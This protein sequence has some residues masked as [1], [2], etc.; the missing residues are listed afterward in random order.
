MRDM[1]DQI[2]IEIREWMGRTA[3]ELHCLSQETKG[4]RERMVRIET[5]MEVNASR[6]SDLR[7][8]FTELRKQVLALSAK[9][10]TIGAIL[11]AGIPMLKSLV[12]SS[13]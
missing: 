5:L 10:A 3:E 1:P 2:A 9:I 12:E 11:S 8:E 13:P 7:G 6:D 4:M